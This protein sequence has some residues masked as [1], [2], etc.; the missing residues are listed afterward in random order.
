ME[1]VAR[2][3]RARRV[4]TNNQGDFKLS[5][6]RILSTIV[7]VKIDVDI[8]S[9]L[10]SKPKGFTN[11]AG[12]RGTGRKPVTRY[13]GS[14]WISTENNSGITQIV[15]KKGT[16][17]VVL[18]RDSIEVLGTGNYEAAFLAVVKNGWTSKDLLRKKPE[19]KKID[20]AFHV[21]RRFFLHDLANQLRTK[22]PMK[23]QV[24]YESEIFPAVILKLEKPAWTY[25]FF[26]NGTVL[27]TGIKDPADVDAPREL[28]KEFFTKYDLVP[29]SAMNVIAKPFIKVPVANKENKKKKLAERYPLAGTWNAL[30]PAPIGFYIRPGTNGKPRFYKYRNMQYEPQTGEWLNRGPINLRGVGPKVVKAFQKVGQPIPEDTRIVLGLKTTTTPAVTSTGEV[31]RAPNWNATKPGFYVRPG[32][33]QQP[34]WFKIPKGLDSGRKTVIATYTK[35]G[36]NIP[37]AVRDIFKIGENVK[38]ETLP[39]HTVTMGLNGILRINGRQ[40]TRLTKKQLITIARNLQIPQV[41]ESMNPERIMAYIREKAGVT[42]ANR[43][44][45]VV[46]NG[47]KYVFLP[48]GRV[49]RTVGKK[50]TERNWVTLPNRNR[51]AKAFLPNALHNNWNKTKNYQMIINYKNRPRTPS[52]TKSSPAVNNNNVNLGNFAANLEKELVNEGHRNAYKNLVGN[53]Y[54]NENFNR[55]LTRLSK[56]PEKAKKANVNRAIK[57]FAKEAIVRARHANYRTQVKVPNWVPLNKQNAFRNAMV[58]VATQVNNKGKYPTQ[59]AV[60][61]AMRA[62]INAEIPK[63]AR[64][65]YNKENVLTGVVTR[66]PSWNPPAKINFNVP[67]RLS[68]PRLGPKKPKAP[69]KPKAPRVDTKK[70]RR[71]GNNE[72]NLGSSMIRL[73]INTQNAYSWNNLVRLGVNKKYKNVWARQPSA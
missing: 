36:R 38:T 1:K 26:G 14:N 47:V 34:Y 15:A 72:N 67:K 48:F 51:I 71:I 18:R 45:N 44:F 63:V 56:L 70:K 55:L 39:N 42:K 68:P 35:A 53:L 23:K 24:R 31:R 2:A 30:K 5:K 60:R 58:E 54:R 59:K 16:Q 37:K 57:T 27:Y 41:N 8:D 61:E 50:R 33:G 20:C 21:N 32:P 28:F 65:A 64:A 7:H 25:Q 62:W 29:Y 19:Y 9:I 43:G 17:T 66:I 10:E 73:G 13:V 4:F 12:Y 52:S 6:A 11:V 3:W 40:A 22:L 69:A 49:Q 46:V